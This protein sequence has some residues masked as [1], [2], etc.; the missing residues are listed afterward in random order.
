MVLVCF[1]LLERSGRL[2]SKHSF[3]HFVELVLPQKSTLYFICALLTLLSA[4]Q[5][6][7][8]LFTVSGT[9]NKVSK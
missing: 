5:H 3:S 6:N 8:D 4:M 9:F 7:A 1:D 2:L